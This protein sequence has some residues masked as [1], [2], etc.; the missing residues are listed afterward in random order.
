[1]GNISMRSLTFILFVASCSPLCRTALGASILVAGTDPTDIG[2]FVSGSNAVSG[3]FSFEQLFTL[4]SPVDVTALAL[5][6]GSFS[7]QTLEV[8]LF[9]G[10]GLAGT[11]TQLQTFNI[12]VPVSKGF[13]LTTI[14]SAVSVPLAA[15]NYSLLFSDPGASSDFI[16][17]TGATASNT[18]EG[19]LGGTDWSTGIDSPANVVFELDGNLASTVPE[20]TPAGQFL[21][22][23]LLLGIGWLIRRRRLGQV[24]LVSASGFILAAAASMGTVKA[25]FIV[26]V[27]QV[28]SNVVA[29]GVGSVN[30]ASLYEDDTFA[31]YQDSIH[32]SS[33]EIELGTAPSQIGIYS[34]LDFSGLTGPASFGN[35]G[36]SNPSSSSG[37]LVG[38]GI[39]SPGLLVLP[40]SYVSGAPLA[41]TAA[42]D[43]STFASLGLTPGTY[44][45]TWGSGPT[46]DS[47]TVQ[48]GAVTVAPE[49]GG[50]FPLLGIVVL[51]AIQSPRKTHTH[52]RSQSFMTDRRFFRKLR[53]T[54]LSA[55]WPECA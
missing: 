37:D 29:T 46:A 52:R 26:N 27:A 2:F 10:S 41:D 12:S 5:D 32:P 28:G 51:L 21:A 48:V 33:G 42:F 49:P 50:M 39:A 45:W 6:A 1:M 47:F 36:L 9:S 16:Y 38:I 22:G 25:S 19:S 18:P 7:A 15:G 53:P 24:Q 8:Q 40:Y 35:G 34:N 14:T 23:V 17:L 30:T 55:Q 4:S 31:L 43:N 44:E 11:G 54:Q 3:A 20:P 13:L